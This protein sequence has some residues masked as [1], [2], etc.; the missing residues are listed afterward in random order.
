METMRRRG[1]NVGFVEHGMWQCPKAVRLWKPKTRRNPKHNL[2]MDVEI[3]VKKD[4]RLK[5]VSVSVDHS[6]WQR[7]TRAQ[8]KDSVVYFFVRK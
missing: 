5:I 2:K 3:A 7:L 6:E 4:A 8:S 1:E